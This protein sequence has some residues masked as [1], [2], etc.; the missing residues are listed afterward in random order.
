M[1]DLLLMMMIIIINRM[2]MIIRNKKCNRCGYEWKP[3]KPD[4]KSCPQCH[5]YKW[6]LTKEEETPEP[7]RTVVPFEDV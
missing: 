5:S 4:P 6:H 3:R 1:N 7:E 2:M